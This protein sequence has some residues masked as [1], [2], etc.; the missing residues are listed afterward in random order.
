MKRIKIFIYFLFFLD[1][2]VCSVAFRNG[3]CVAGT[4]DNEI[5][6]F[7]LNGNSNPE[8]LV[9]GH[10]DNSLSA[11]A[12]HPR[13]NVFATGGEDC[14]LRFWNADKMSFITF[15]TTPFVPLTPPPAIR[16][17]VFSSNGSQ[18]A[19]GYENGYIEIY[20]TVFVYLDLS[21]KR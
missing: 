17:L 20:P 11:L 9:Q 2:N 14:S 13:Q 15:Y 8:L 10:H 12:C 6:G 19:V 16:S 3:Y 7:E 18:I 21:F 1:I 5:Y 4:R